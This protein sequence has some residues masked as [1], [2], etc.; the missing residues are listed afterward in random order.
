MN[1]KEFK[2]D[3]KA[4]VEGV[5]QEI[6]ENCKILIA[7]ANNKKYN[8]EII[9]L[10][11]PHRNR[12]Q[13]NT[14]PKDVMENIVITAIARHVLLDWQGITENDDNGNEVIVE[15]SKDKAIEYLTAYPD[16]REL[17]VDYASDMSIFQENLEE[18]IVEEIKND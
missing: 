2:T 9:K 3:K 5:W 1:I 4:E 7:R 8:D 13:R 12:L 17:V 15:Y 14:L 11:K 10:C 16:F 18:E 6:A